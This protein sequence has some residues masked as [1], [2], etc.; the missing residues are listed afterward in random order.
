M[1]LTDRSFTYYLLGTALACAAVVGSLAAQFVMELL[2]CPL[3]I[4]Q[5]LLYL[6]ASIVLVAGL[7]AGGHLRLLTSFIGLLCGL[8][9]AS[10]GLYQG[11]IA[12][13]EA[14]GQCGSP[15]PYETTLWWLADNV[16]YLLFAPEASCADVAAHTFLGMS[17]PFWSLFSGLTLALLL[18]LS[19]FNRK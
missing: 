7:M 1:K 17:M 11:W 12:S 14:L 3:C 2:P 15:G 8:G 6:L 16:S 9:A 4:G 13:A 19:V 18:T 10:I 5:R